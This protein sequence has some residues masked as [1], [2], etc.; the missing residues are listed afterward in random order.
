MSS[1]SRLFPKNTFA[2]LA[3]IPFE[4]LESLI[5]SIMDRAIGDTM[6]QQ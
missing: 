4:H 5:I 2:A 3:L 1:H 6:K